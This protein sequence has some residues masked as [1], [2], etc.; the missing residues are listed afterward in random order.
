MEEQVAIKEHKKDEERKTAK[1]MKKLH[2][3]DNWREEMKLQA[4]KKKH[5]DEE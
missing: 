2:R 4:E 5:E 3:N 1:Y